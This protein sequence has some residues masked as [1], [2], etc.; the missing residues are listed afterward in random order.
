MGDE[1]DGGGGEEEGGGGEEVKGGWLVLALGGAFW[2]NLNGWLTGGGR[3]VR[4][5][6]H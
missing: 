5:V 3:L 6:Y 2:G 4:W 1:E